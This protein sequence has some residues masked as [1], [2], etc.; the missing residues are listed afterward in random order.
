[1]NSENSEASDSFGLILNL[2]GKAI[3]KKTDKYVAFSNLSVYYIWKK[4]KKSKKKKKKKNKKKK[5]KKKSEV[6][7]LNYLMDHILC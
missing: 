1:M 2:A 3:F 6:I 4:N 5:K 7:N